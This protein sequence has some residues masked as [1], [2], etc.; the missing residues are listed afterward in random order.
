TARKTWGWYRLEIL[1][2]LMNGAVLVALAAGVFLESLRR[3]RQPPEVRPGPMIAFAL[4]GLA[5]NVTAVAILAG[6]RSN[7]NLRAALPPVRGR[8]CRGRGRSP[9]DGL[10]RRRPAHGARHQRRHRRRSGPPPAGSD[11]CPHGGGPG[12]HRAV[13]GRG[14]HLRD[15]GRPRRSRPPRLEH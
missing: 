12:G 11:R 6:G 13:P 2:A 5:G 10:D 7:P 4:A 8:L 3:L 14:G 1:A 9:P 15:P